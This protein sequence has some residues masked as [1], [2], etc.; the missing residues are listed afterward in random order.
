M[1]ERERERERARTREGEKPAFSCTGVFCS[2]CVIFFAFPCSCWTGE[3][4]AFQGTSEVMV[5]AHVEKI[6]R[7]NMGMMNLG[8]RV[9]FFASPC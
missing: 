9:V 7:A 3:T 8:S 2:A 4:A 5:R 6:V 1:R